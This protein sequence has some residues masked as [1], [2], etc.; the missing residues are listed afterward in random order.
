MITVT[1]IVPALAAGVTTVSDVGETTV[2]AVSATF[3]KS[4]LVTSVK[5]V[6]VIVIVCPPDDAP[7]ELSR[8]V[9][10]GSEPPWVNVNCV[11]A[12][13]AEVPPGVTTVTLT[14]PADAAG[15]V[16]VSEPSALTTNAAAAVAPK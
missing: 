5:F 16:A 8:A 9:T 7:D 2:N 1:W 4:T 11:A 13:V 6:P 15:T 10:V 3:P 12:L 14:L